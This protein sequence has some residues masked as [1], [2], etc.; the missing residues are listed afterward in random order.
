MYVKSPVCGVLPC[1]HPEPIPAVAVMNLPHHKAPGGLCK[2][3]SLPPLPPWLTCL[4]RYTRL[5]FLEFEAKESRRRVLCCFVWLLSQHNDS[6]V[7]VSSVHSFLSP[8]PVALWV[9]TTLLYPLTCGAAFRSQLPARSCHGLLCGILARGHVLLL[10]LLHPGGGRTRSWVGG[11]F[12]L[13]IPSGRAG[14]SSSP[15]PPPPSRLPSS[16]AWAGSVLEVSLP[17]GVQERLTGVCICI[18]PAMQ[19][20]ERSMLTP[21][22][23]ATHTHTHTQLL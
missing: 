7:H 14:S 6:S 9:S 20:V 22:P 5:H 18:F 1:I 12:T 3:P 21:P 17:T 15:T 4:S 23:P 19:M 8:S 10:L 16:S 11:C 2:A 13:C